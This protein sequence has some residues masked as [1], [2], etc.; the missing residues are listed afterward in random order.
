MTGVSFLLEAKNAKQT[1]MGCNQLLLVW[2][3]PGGIFG[4]ASRGELRF[5]CICAVGLC[6]GVFYNGDRGS[7][8][9]K[10]LI[11]FTNF[12]GISEVVERVQFLY[13]CF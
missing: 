2:F 4:R 9:K 12:I 7:V 11:L 1:N 8:E 3:A 5:S 10:K 13:Q 6:V